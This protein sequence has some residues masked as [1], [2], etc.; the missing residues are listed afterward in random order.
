MRR[1][2]HAFP[3]PQVPA[4]T[5][6]SP[7]FH[8]VH[9]ADGHGERPAS[10]GDKDDRQTPKF[11]DDPVRPPQLTCWGVKSRDMCDGTVPEEGGC[12]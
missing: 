1:G 7:G 9:H 2:S 12:L 4:A 10:R 11:W 5:T 8:I 6:T 3:A